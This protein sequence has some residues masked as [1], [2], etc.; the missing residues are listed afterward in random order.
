MNVTLSD[1]RTF[2]RIG[3]NFVE[4]TTTRSNDASFKSV[5]IVKNVKR[6]FNDDAVFER[7]DKKVAQKMNVEEFETVET[8]ILVTDKSLIRI[9]I[10]DSPLILHKVFDRDVASPQHTRERH[11]YAGF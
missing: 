9:P 4:T 11:L 7:N 3:N 5:E 2:R 8:D 10:Y 1:E 6:S